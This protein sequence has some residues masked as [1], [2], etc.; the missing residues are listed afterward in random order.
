MPVR[1]SVF[2][3]FA[4]LPGAMLA[5]AE[6]TV[7]APAGSRPLPHPDILQLPAKTSTASTV[8][9]ISPAPSVT[10]S[11]SPSMNGNTVVDENR[12]IPR[13]ADRSS[14]S[15]VGGAE[16]RKTLP[17]N[18]G[19]FSIL[20]DLW[21][22]LIVLALIGA[23]SLMLKRFMP[24]RKLIGGSDVLRIVARTSVGPKQQLML[25]KIGR[26]LLLV[27][28][29]PERINALTTIDDPDQV[30]LLMGEAASGRSD[31]MANT[32]AATMSDQAIAY[33]DPRTDEDAT[34]ATRGHVQGL[35]QKV[36]Q[37]AGKG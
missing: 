17:R 15:T 12:E 28:V 4:I 25:V 1:L 21:P 20:S 7:A 11:G 30:A 3:S 2:I 9:S 35:L 8:E 18:S 22:L 10:V 6:G 29:A 23:V 33:K 13:R 5:R 24:N 34:D 14:G 27:G 31:S 32:F 26:Q 37:L 16:T 19:G 36:R